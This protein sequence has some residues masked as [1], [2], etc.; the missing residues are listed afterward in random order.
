[1]AVCLVCVRVARDIYGARPFRWWFLCGRVYGP[2][3]SFLRWLQTMAEAIAQQFAQFYYKTFDE[4][5][6]GLAP[7]YVR[8]DVVVLGKCMRVHV[9]VLFDPRVSIRTCPQHTSLCL[10]IL[11]FHMFVHVYVYV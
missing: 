6:A 8:G 4:N 9:H 5:R 1:M 10:F 3:S 2:F 11:Y 7:L